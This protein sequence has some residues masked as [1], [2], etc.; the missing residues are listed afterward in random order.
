M[1]WPG[2]GLVAWFGEMP[3]RYTAPADREWCLCRCHA[4]DRGDQ[5]ECQH[6]DWLSAAYFYAQRASD[7]ARF[8]E[9]TA[10]TADAIAAVFACEQCLAGHCV[11]LLDT[12]SLSDWQDAKVIQN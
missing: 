7:L 12:R 5:K 1:R 8:R 6:R 2:S 9:N 3:M 4:V 10:D 11:A